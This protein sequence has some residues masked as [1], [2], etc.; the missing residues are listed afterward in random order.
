[1][2]IPP[3]GRLKKYEVSDQHLGQPRYSVPNL[4][5]GSLPQEFI[6]AT[7]SGERTSGERS[8]GS[9][10][11]EKTRCKHDYTLDL[12]SVG[13]MNVR[14][15]ETVSIRAERRRDETRT[16]DQDDGQYSEWHILYM[17]HALSKTNK[18]RLGLS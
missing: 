15:K 11:R 5:A 7:I 13:I 17:Q 9:K 8:H 2:L 10:N 14:D 16:T 18:R 3:I 4:H 1:M 12:C 6:A